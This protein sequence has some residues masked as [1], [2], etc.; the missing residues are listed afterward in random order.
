MRS[1]EKCRRKKAAYLFVLYKRGDI[2]KEKIDEFTN[3]IHEL[4]RTDEEKDIV[5]T[6]EISS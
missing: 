5:N 3:K 6:G 2:Q 4:L 1:D